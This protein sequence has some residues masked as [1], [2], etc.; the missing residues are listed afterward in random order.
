[1]TTKVTERI[2][3]TPDPALSFW[4]TPTDVADELVRQALLPGYGL[5]EAAGGVSQVRVLEPSA[6]EGHLAR[7]IRAHL[8]YAHITAVEPSPARAAVLRA[9]PDVVDG[10]VQSTLENYLNAV[11]IQ[12]LTGGWTAFDLVLMNPPFTLDGRPEAWAEHVLAIYT[13]PHL[14]A[15]GGTLGAVVPHVV[16]TGKSK[17]VRAVR[18]LLGPTHSRY[19]DGALDCEHGRIEPCER[20]AFA[21]VEAAVSTALMWAHK[22]F[23]RD[24]E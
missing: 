8:P 5:G 15:R 23:D 21:P 22:P 7:A 1:M 9:L 4:P 2:A 3:Y 11:A 14:L 17:R 24:E 13:D 10:V 19:L 6:G 16:L 12:A 18:E 20:G